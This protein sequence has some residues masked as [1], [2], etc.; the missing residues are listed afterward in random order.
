MIL[1]IWKTVFFHCL[2][3]K[4]L[5]IIFLSFMLHILSYFMQKKIYS[6]KLAESIDFFR[7]KNVQK[8][9]NYSNYQNNS[10]YSQ[11]NKYCSVIAC[12]CTLFMYCTSGCIGVRRAYSPMSSFAVKMVKFCVLTGTSTV[13]IYFLKLSFL[14]EQ[15]S[16][17]IKENLHEKDGPAIRVHGVDYLLQSHFLIFC[18]S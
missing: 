1:F 17:W 4:I 3:A 2:T 18:I 16:V 9:H 15:K 14:Q 5:Q 8:G 10:Q 13:T 11:Y 6:I 12:V 7:K